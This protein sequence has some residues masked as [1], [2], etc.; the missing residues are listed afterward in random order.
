MRRRER[1]ILLKALSSSVIPGC[2]GSDSLPFTT[3]LFD[4]KAMES[5]QL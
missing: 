2:P 5:R 3:L 1:K 4:G